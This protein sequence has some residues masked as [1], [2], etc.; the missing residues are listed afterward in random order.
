MAKI[1]PTVASP[2]DTAMPTTVTAAAGYGTPAIVGGT[3]AAPMTEP[4]QL[5]QLSRIEEKAARIE[6]KFARYEA[7]LTRAEASLER[8]AHKVDA[9]AGTMDFAAIRGEIAA[10]R[11]RVDA[12][13]RAATLFTTAIVT[14]ILT[15]VLTIL[16]L[17]FGVPGL[18]PK[19][20]P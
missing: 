17:R 9:A 1:E 15:V 5:D 14:A 13:P 16:V 7:V 8:S 19:L 4:R 12:T 11:D 10:L 18:M 3:E 6:E 2:A 20:L